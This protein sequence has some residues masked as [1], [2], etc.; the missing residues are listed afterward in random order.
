L[1]GDLVLV[2][3]VELVD[4]VEAAATAAAATARAAAVL[5]AGMG[6]MTSS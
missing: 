4:S 3:E 2:V 5:P 6:P 1:G